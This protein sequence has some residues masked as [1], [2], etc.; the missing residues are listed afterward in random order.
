MSSMANT[1]ESKPQTAP[2]AS[3][4]AERLISTGEHLLR[5]QQARLMTA[6]GDYERKRTDRM[7]F[8][9]GEMQRLADEAEAE[10][11]VIDRNW[12]QECAKIEQIIG[13]LKALRGV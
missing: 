1:P 10:L 6:R 11:L 7:N 2:T 3:I 8:Y 13:K 4:D 12:S 5:T 9:R